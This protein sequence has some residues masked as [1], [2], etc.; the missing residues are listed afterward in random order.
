MIFSPFSRHSFLARSLVFQLVVI[1]GDAEEAVSQN[2]MR[3]LQAR[4][5]AAAHSR[6]A[7]S[8][9]SS[10][11]DRVAQPQAPQL[12]RE[13]SAKAAQLPSSVTTCLQFLPLC[14]THS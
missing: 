4:P 8:S 13:S 2:W 6:I 14:L 9:A 10:R 11:L 12:R 1:A 3:I 7:T 5:P